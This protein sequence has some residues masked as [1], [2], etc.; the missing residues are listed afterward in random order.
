[1]Q[2]IDL[3]LPSFLSIETSPNKSSNHI[4]WIK[5]DKYDHWYRA[6]D[7][8]ASSLIVKVAKLLVDTETSSAS[9]QK[10]KGLLAETAAK[11]QEELF[12]PTM[13]KLLRTYMTFAMDSPDFSQASLQEIVIRKDKSM[14][15][16]L[17]TMFNAPILKSGRSNKANLLLQTENIKEDLLA[18]STRE[19]EEMEIS[20][21]KVDIEIEES[22]KEREIWT[23]LEL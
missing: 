9:T 10:D 8:L 4:A 17:T 12:R 13:T 21:L 18:P 20:A 6:L 2:L 11:A 3:F 22:E 23:D 19:Q 14:H 16:L 5:D 15:A 1:M 7:T